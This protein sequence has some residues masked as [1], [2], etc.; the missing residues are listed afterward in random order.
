MRNSKVA[1]YTATILAHYLQR[2]QLQSTYSMSLML[3]RSEYR[4]II[5][6]QQ[7][8][9]R[10]LQRVPLTMITRKLITSNSCHNVHFS[11][12]LSN[13]LVKDMALECERLRS[14]IRCS[15]GQL[16]IMSITYCSRRATSGVTAGLERVTAPITNTSPEDKSLH[17]ENHT[18][19]IYQTELLCMRLWFSL[20]FWWY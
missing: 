11:G 4:T 17:S 14:S 2:S 9:I 1:V 15:A 10:L 20:W 12:H 19:D 6:L 16:W 18:C 7:Y 3:N 13:G 5:S 8:L